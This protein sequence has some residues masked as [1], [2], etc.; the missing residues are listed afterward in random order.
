MSAP[1]FVGFQPNL[2]ANDVINWSQ[3]GNPTG[4]FLGSMSS[5][6]SN[7]GIAATVSTDIPFFP[8][9]IAIVCPATNCDWNTPATVPP[10]FRAGDSLFWTAN[11]PGTGNGPL[12]VR[13]SQSVAGAGAYIQPFAIGPFTA[14]LFACVQGQLCNLSDASTLT[15]FAAVPSDSNG[16]PVFLGVSDTVADITEIIFTITSITPDAGCPPGSSVFCD[17]SFNFAVDSLYM[18]AVPEPATVI[19]IL[20]GGS[21]MLGYRGLTSGRRTATVASG[22]RNMVGAVGTMREQVC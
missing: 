14:Q 6:T 4:P 11:R 19:F 1:V 10:S 20:L 3:L 22:R 7:N 17:D 9:S 21:L 8:N 16:D 2:S 13:F 5:V 12:A 18:K 15:T